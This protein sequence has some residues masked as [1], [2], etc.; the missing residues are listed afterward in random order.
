MLAKTFMVFNRYE[1]PDVE[2]MYI[3]REYSV[4]LKLGRIWH[5]GTLYHWGYGV[6]RDF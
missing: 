2:S 5:F 4:P 1:V 3:F 6:D